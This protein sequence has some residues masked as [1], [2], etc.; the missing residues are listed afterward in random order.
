[1]SKLKGLGVAIA[2]C[3]SASCIRSASAQKLDATVLYRL[4]PRLLQPGQP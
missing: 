3:C 1:M 4:D 2:I